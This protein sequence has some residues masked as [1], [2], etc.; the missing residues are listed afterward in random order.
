MYLLNLY[1]QSLLSKTCYDNYNIEKIHL[2]LGL[3]IKEILQNETKNVDTQ[4]KLKKKTTNK[5][6]IYLVYECN[7]CKLIIRHILLFYHGVSVRFTNAGNSI[8][9]GVGGGADG[10]RAKQQRH[11]SALYE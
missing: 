5:H 8:W 10:S 3:R 11:F 4:K 9:H 7:Q 6:L 2:Q 1:N